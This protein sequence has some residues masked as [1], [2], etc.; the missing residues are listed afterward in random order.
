MAVPVLELRS[1]RGTGGGPEKTILAGAIAADP[2]KSRVTV[3]YIRDARDQVFHIDRR[4][5]ALGVDYVELVERHSFDPTVLRGLRQLVAA[6]SS[7]IVH[8]HDYK[9]DLLAWLL[10]KRTGVVPIATAH[11]WTGHTMRERLLYYPAHRRLLGRFPLVLAVSSQIRD[12]LIAHGAAPTRVRVLLNGIDPVVYRRDRSAE[13]A[14]RERFGVPHS[15]TV[16]GAVGRLEPQKRFD[17]L[18]EAFDEARRGLPGLQLLIAGD[19]SQRSALQSRI[20]ER[21]LSAV[22][23]LVGH[24]TDVVALHHVFDAFV[25]SSDYEGTPNAV[26]EAMALETAVIATDA[27]G[28]REICRDRVEG[29]IVP[30]N[31][32]AALASAIVRTMT[33]ADAR[34]LQVRRA[35]DRVERELTFD[36]RVKALDHLYSTLAEASTCEHG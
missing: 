1:V 19:G 7:R 18:I 4:A 15:A 28:T 12:E 36:H 16:I 26:L 5:A 25:Q 11:G 33:D 27:G 20:V 30:R 32:M 13:R 35:R 22:C 21:G 3:C 9:T 34:T 6:R 2:V 17:L 8:S 31:D 10:A 23:R 29:T 24:Q 14:A